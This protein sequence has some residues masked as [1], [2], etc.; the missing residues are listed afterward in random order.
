MEV[1]KKRLRDEKYRVY[2]RVAANVG[3]YAS[4]NETRMGKGKGKF[5]HWAA[6]IAVSQIVFEISGRMHEQVAR[7]AFRLA[8]NKLPGTS[9]APLF[10]LEVT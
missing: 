6:K 3:V 8:G 2:T 10:R 1:I 5:D 4:G 9:A 7:D